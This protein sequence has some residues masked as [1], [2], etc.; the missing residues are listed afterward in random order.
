MIN[1]HGPS[2]VE[3]LP[4]RKVPKKAAIKALLYDTVPDDKSDVTLYITGSQLPAWSDV[5]SIFVNFQEFKV[6]SVKGVK[7]SNIRKVKEGKLYAVEIP[8]AELPP[9]GTKPLVALVTKQ[10]VLTK[11]GDHPLVK[12]PEPKP[13]PKAKR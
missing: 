12:K 13:K 5:E 1:V 6:K 10:G 3:T 2:G 8:G 7:G 4:A 11:Q 9:P